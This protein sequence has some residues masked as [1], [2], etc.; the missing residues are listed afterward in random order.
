MLT[1]SVEWHKIQNNASNNTRINT[2]LNK[3]LTLLI[4]IY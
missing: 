2:I 3:R 4:A 1:R